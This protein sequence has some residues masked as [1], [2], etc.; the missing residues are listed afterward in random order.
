M[1]D[2]NPR[3]AVPTPAAG[4]FDHVAAVY[5]WLEY[6]AFGRT[7]QRARTA[8]LPA[9]RACTK[10]LVVGDGD[11]RCLDALLRCA[12]GAQV[13]SVDASAGMLRRARARAVRAGGADRVDFVH[14]DIRRLRIE[15][16]Q[17]DAVLTLF[18]LDCFL[19]EDVRRLTA[20]L[21]A[22]LRPGGLWL[23]ADFAIPPRGWRRWH[24]RVWVGALYAFFRLTTGLE[25]RV[26]PDAEAAILAGGMART[27]ERRYRAGLL[28]SVL[29]RKA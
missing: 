20:A 18:V 26:L 28:R 2:A 27:A 5:R 11:G 23:F 19:D 25:A 8:H 7:L 29:F 16:D 3:D 9:L 24:A 6:L 15:P 14:A 1:P 17:Y 13:T 22:G 4:G 21:A 10:V 12:P